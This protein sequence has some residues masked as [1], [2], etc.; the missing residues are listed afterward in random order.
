MYVSHTISAC[1]RCHQAV[2]WSL[3]YSVTMFTFSCSPWMLVASKYLSMDHRRFSISWSSCLP[4][5]L[6]GLGTSTLIGGATLVLSTPPATAFLQSAQSVLVSSRPTW[7]SFT[8]ALS[9]SIEFMTTTWNS[10]RLWHCATTSW[11]R[12]PI[13][14][15]TSSAS[16]I[17]Y[18]NISKCS[19]ISVKAISTQTTRF[20][21]ALSKSTDFSLL[22]FPFFALELGSLP[23]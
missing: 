21:M 5:C 13:C 9:A 15:P 14:S 3:R 8:W 19:L 1:F 11:L 6:I 4:L 10:S 22:F 2:A 12:L 17:F 20:S 18:S 16:S 7:S 23:L